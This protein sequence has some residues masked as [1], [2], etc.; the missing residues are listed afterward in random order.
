MKIIIIAMKLAGNEATL[1]IE[2]ASKTAQCS[3]EK[4]AYT[5][6]LSRRAHKAMP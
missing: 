1:A 2:P 6:V 4:K 5:C 3:Q